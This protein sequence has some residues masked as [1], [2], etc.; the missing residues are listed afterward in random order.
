MGT[1]PIFES[2]FDCLTEMTEEETLIGKV[3]L[4]ETED[5]TYII[6]SRANNKLPKNSLKFGSVLES[7]EGEERDKIKIKKSKYYTGGLTTSDN[8]YDKTHDSYIIISNPK[9]KLIIMKADE[10]ILSP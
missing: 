2:D 6:K 4:I 3:K 5:K 10:M 7:T 9:G 8:I 1:H